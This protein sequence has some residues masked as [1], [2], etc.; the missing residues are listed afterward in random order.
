LVPEKNVSQLAQTLNYIIE[1][2]DIWNSIALAARKKI[3]DEFEV[4]KTSEQL[5]EIFYNLLGQYVSN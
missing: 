3:E 5:E 4:K 1:H 2:P